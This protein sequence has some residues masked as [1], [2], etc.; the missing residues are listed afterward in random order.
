[1]HFLEIIC[2]DIVFK[3]CRYTLIRFNRGRGVMTFRGESKEA[4]RDPHPQSSR[5]CHKI[6]IFHEITGKSNFY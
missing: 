4:K 5:K 1:M 3:F 2:A 6:N